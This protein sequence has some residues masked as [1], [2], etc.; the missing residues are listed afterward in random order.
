MTILKFEIKKMLGNKASRAAIVVLILLMT[1]LCIGYIQGGYYVQEDGSEIHGIKAAAKMR[2]AKEPWKGPV[3]EDVI[4]RVIEENGKVY[5]DAGNFNDDGWL[6]DSAF[7]RQQGYYDLR[8]LINVTYRSGFTDYDYFTINRLTPGD[9]AD[10]YNR[11]ENVFDEWLG[12]EEV[13]QGFSDEKRAYIREHALKLE[14]PYY[15]EY[16]DGWNKVKEMNSVLIFGV[17][18]VICV[19]LAGNFSAECQTKADAIYFS[20]PLGRKKGNQMKIVAGFILATVIYWGVMLLG[21][22]IMLLAYGASGA[23]VPIQLEFWKCLYSLTQEEAWILIV[24][25]GYIGCLS[26]SGLTMLMSARF[27]SSFVAIIL[28]FLIIMVPAMAAQSIYS[29]LWQDILSLFPHGAI[30]AYDYFTTYVLYQF[31][32]RIYSPFELLIPL[33]ILVAVITIPFTYCCFQKYRA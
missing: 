21:S 28:S 33:H 31:G 11:R 4:A 25:L 24:F 12:R 15:Y 26:M 19:I 7:S 29:V 9:A 17:V 23:Q 5:A 30:M 3:T 13:A 1:G 2:E 16:F 22:A 6:S 10:F 32:G 8:E 14:T 20:T 27:K 18:I